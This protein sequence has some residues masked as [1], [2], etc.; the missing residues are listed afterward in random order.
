MNIYWG[1][2]EKNQIDL[3][4]PLDYREITLIIDERI[5]DFSH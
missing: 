1:G 4:K 3:L 5:I 2:Y